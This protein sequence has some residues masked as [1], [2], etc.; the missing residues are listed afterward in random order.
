[1]SHCCC[2]QTASSGRRF[3]VLGLL[4]KTLLVYCVLVFGGGTLINT[5]NSVAVETGKLMQT[6]TLVETTINWADTH[7]HERLAHALRRL[8][9]GAPI[10]CGE[11]STDAVS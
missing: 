11:P 8:A 10:H 4:F 6:V 1:M 7:G 5:G 3:S 9:H 2:C